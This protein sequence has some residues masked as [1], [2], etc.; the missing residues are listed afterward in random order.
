MLEEEFREEDC[1]AVGVF[2]WNGLLDKDAVIIGLLL[3][4]DSEDVSESGTSKII[5]LLLCLL[6]PSSLKIGDLCSVEEYPLNL[7]HSLLNISLAGAA[8]FSVLIEL[9]E[10][11]LAC[12][13]LTL[14]WTAAAFGLN[15]G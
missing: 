15:E 12:V 2:T 14:C 7:P 10:A 13:E 9:V 5:S 6:K 8:P 11:K 4:D 3:D 1:E